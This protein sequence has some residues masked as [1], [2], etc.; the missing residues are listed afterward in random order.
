MPQRSKIDQ[1]PP[2][3]R[4]EFQ[5][6][7]LKKNFCDYEGFEAWFEE[8]GYQVSRSSAHRFGQGFQAKCEAIRIATEQAKAIVTVVGDDEG[9]LNEALIRMIQQLSFDI[10]LKAGEAGE[11]IADILPKMGVMVAKLGKASI[12]Q[13]KHAAEVR[14][15]ALTDAASV[16]DEMAKQQGMNEEQARFWREKVLMGA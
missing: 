16:V 4:A 13:K 3:I 10:L 9:N 14:K 15:V 2:E 11:G 1:L 7:L 12:D 5:Q 6:A 8:R